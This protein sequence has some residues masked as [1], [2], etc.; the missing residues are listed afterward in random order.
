[1]KKIGGFKDTPSLKAHK[2]A[3]VTQLLG[4]LT[5]R[6]GIRI[7]NIGP[8]DIVD[9]NTKLLLGLVWTIIK[10]YQITRTETFKMKVGEAKPDTSPR[11]ELLNWVRSKIPSY[12]IKNFV[13]VDS[14]LYL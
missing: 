11:T 3:N 2:L 12:N 10:H 7:E 1:M 14:Y 13:G 4:F 5:D 8:V 9:G 6:E